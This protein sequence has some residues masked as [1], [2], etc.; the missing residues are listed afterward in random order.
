M[1]NV[2][3]TILSQYA[4]SATLVQLIQNMN[5]YIDPAANIQA[6]YNTVW[7]V[8]TAEG[9]GLDI[10]GRIVGLPNGRVVPIP[11]TAGAFG[12]KN[13]DIPA[14]WQNFGNVNQAGTGGPFF[15][16]EVTTGGYKLNDPSFKVLILTKALANIVA[17]TAPALNQLIR[18]LFPGR[19]RCYTL[20]L[21]KM[22]MRFVFE[23]K[24]TTIE[25]AIL[26]YSG[27]LPSPGGVGISILQ[28]SANTF[29]FNEAGSLV[30]PF[31]YGT[32]YNGG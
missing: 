1:L 27:V 17:T 5:S 16:G 8:D 19:G 9:F 20:D 23:F 32:F 6:F 18:N 12:F 25:Y 24:L 14:D 10:W 4:Q 22:K 30:K 26:A 3:Q 28:V 29:G 15:N 7:N 13:T 2:E 11:G 21:G 31:D